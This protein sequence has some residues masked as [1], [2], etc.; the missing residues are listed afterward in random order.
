DGERP[1][2][3]DENVALV[4]EGVVVLQRQVLDHG[5]TLDR[6]LA[7]GAERARTR[8]HDA[9]VAVG[10]KTAKAVGAGTEGGGQEIARQPGLVRRRVGGNLGRG[11]GSTVQGSDGRAF[12]GNLQTLEHA[13]ARAKSMLMP[14]AARVWVM[15]RPFTAKA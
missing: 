5:R 14:R 13:A 12:V 3:A 1:G 9:P 6:A 10:R 15:A 4:D 2:A 7:H 11:P 8:G